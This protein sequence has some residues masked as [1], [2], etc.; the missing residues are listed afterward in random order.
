MR[1]GQTSRP[2]NDLEPPRASLL[3]QHTVRLVRSDQLGK[4]F[5][6][7]PSWPEVGAQVQ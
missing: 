2:A 5:G 3:Q 6:L 1:S 4:I 7:G